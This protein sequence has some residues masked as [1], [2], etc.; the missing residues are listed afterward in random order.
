MVTRSAHEMSAAMAAGEI[1]SE[2]LT[3]QH[4]DRIAEVD[5]DVHAFLYLDHE[6]ALAQARAR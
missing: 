1:T 5:A 4:F 6:G 3:Q 2:A